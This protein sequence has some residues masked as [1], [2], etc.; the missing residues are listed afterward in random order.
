M[1][2]YKQPQD[3]IDAF[4]RIE[5]VKN[6]QEELCCEFLKYIPAVILK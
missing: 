1:T 6:T 5:Q 4:S 2:K 3:G